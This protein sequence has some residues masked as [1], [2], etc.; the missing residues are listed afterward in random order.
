[1]FSH[2]T[3]SLQGLPTIRAF[4]AQEILKKEFAAH[5][6]NHSAAAYMFM[7]CGRTFGFWLD[8]TCIVY[9]GLVILSFLVMGTG[10]LIS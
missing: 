7:S 9:I 3:A 5:L 2:L 1:M 6:N 10:N 8:M 4:N